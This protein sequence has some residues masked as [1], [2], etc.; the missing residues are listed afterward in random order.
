MKNLYGLV[1][2]RMSEPVFHG[3]CAPTG[4]FMPETVPDVDARARISPDV[5]ASQLPWPFRYWEHR[6]AHTNHLPR[7]SR[8]IPPRPPA[9]N[10]AP[11]LT[12]ALPSCT[13]ASTRRALGE[14]AR[15]LKKC[16]AARAAWDRSPCGSSASWRHSESSGVRDPAGA[17]AAA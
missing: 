5:C 6:R 4:P 3:L 12:Q 1:N 10:V 15:K 13:S 17:A 8:T 14:P 9:R 2:A 11:A 7:G 16:R